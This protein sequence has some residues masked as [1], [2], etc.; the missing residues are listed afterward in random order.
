[1]VWY[2]IFLCIASN[3]QQCMAMEHS[4]SHDKAN[5]AQKEHQACANALAR[6]PKPTRTLAKP[7]KQPFNAS[8]QDP[9]IRVVIEISSIADYQKGEVANTTAIDFSSNNLSE[10][11][12]LHGYTKLQEIDCSGNEFRIVPP[13]LFQCLGLQRIFLQHN[14]IEIIPSAIHMFGHLTVLN[15]AHNYLRELPNE[16]S[17]LQKLRDLNVSHNAITSIP[18]SI[19]RLAQLF[20]FNIKNNQLT[21]TLVD[22]LKQK[23]PNT[24]IT[25]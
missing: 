19:A 10:L 14:L 3:A 25:W 5:I 24:T 12:Q 17:R 8:E 18:A 2:I 11:P 15:L 20:H 6:K 21:Q 7:K 9:K 4:C 1:M 16:L 13:P 23:M 22:A